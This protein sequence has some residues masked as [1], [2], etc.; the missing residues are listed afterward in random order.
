M[1]PFNAS[2]WNIK[3]VFESVA[4]AEKRLNGLKYLWWSWDGAL[5]VA[6]AKSRLVREHARESAARDLCIKRDVSLTLG[7]KDLIE[8]R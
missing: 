8:L 1:L 5:N 2:Q 4:E 3:R 6:L 7:T